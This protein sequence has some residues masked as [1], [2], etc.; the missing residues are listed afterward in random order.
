MTSL[1]VP[2]IPEVGGVSAQVSSLSIPQIPQMGGVSTQVTS[3]LVPHY[4][5]YNLR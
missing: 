2:Q 4:L 5:K 1:P 3:L